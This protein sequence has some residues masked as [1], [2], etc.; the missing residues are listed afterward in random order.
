MSRALVTGGT[1]FLGS[2]LSRALAAEGWEVRGTYLGHPASPE[3]CPV[4]PATTLQ[5]LDVTQPESVRKAV[6]EF[7]PDAIFHFAGQAF[8]QRSFADPAGTYAVNLLG[9]LHVLEAMRRHVPRASMVFAGSG[10][11]YGAPRQVPTPEEA[12]LLPTSPYAASK[13]AADLLC[14]QY[15]QS[16]ET[17]VLRLRIFGTTGPGKN[18]DSCNDFASQVAQREREATGGPIRVGDLEKRRDITDVRDAVRAML[19][20]ERKGESGAAYNLGSGEARTVRSVLETLLG[21]A[22]RPLE[23]QAEPARYRPGDEPVHLASIEKLRGLGWAPTIPFDRT[24]EDILNGWRG[25]ANG[26][27][28]SKL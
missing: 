27:S 9:T 20:V 12:P 7:R 11:E 3:G 8:V 6:E 25:R 19:A 22:H 16:F 13:A 23:V 26:G 17:R 5:P 24:L 14:Y 18:G 2:D 28:V 1:G 4:L 21:L 10:T 15:A